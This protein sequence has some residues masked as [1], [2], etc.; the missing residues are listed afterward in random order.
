[1][2]YGRSALIGAGIT[3]RTIAYRQSMTAEWATGGAVVLKKITYMKD[4]KMEDI[5]LKIIDARDELA[6]AKK[7]ADVERVQKILDAIIDALD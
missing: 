5:R 7:W 2:A 3:T 6:D 1:M 4:T